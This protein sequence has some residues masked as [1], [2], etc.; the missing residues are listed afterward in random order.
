MNGSIEILCF[1]F[2]KFVYDEPIFYYNTLVYRNTFNMLNQS[3]NYVLEQ[4]R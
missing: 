1:N 2:F 4:I 3:K